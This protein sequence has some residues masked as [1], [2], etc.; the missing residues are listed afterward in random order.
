LGRDLIVEF[1]R[2]KRGNAEKG[3]FA[4]KCDTW[5]CKRDAPIKGGTL[6][7]GRGG[8]ESVRP[9]PKTLCLSAG[10]GKRKRF[11]KKE[12]EKKGMA[13]RLTPARRK[14][15]KTLDEFSKKVVRAFLR[16]LS[17]WGCSLRRGGKGRLLGKGG[18]VSNA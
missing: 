5:A 17:V 7:E 4:E 18:L 15:E 9:K 13:G 14:N 3:G 16:H 1:Q 2:E 11:K 12:E 8:D 10:G 6:R